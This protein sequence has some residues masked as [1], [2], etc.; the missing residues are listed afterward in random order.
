MGRARPT[1]SRTGCHTTVARQPATQ[2]GPRARSAGT[3]DSFA[4]GTL[5]VASGLPSPDASTI[6]PAAS[7]ARGFLQRDAAC[8]APAVAPQPVAPAEDPRFLRVKGQV[9]QVALKEKS[10]PP[11]KAK[12]AE[13][14]GAAVGP[15]NEVAAQAGAAQVDTMAAA[16]PGTFD[17]AAFIAAVRK[18]IDDAAPKNLDEADNLKNSGKAGLVKDQVAGMVTKGKEDSAKDIKGTTDAPP[19]TSQA[20]PKDVKAMSPESTGSPPPPV[21]GAEAMPAP[22]GPDQTDLGAGPCSIKSKMADAKVTDEQLAK[23]N[24][25]QLNKALDSKQQAEQHAASAPA[26]VKAEEAKQLDAAKSGAGAATTS[27]L[28]SMH[29]ARA[30]VLG[31]VGAG[32]DQ[33]K[34]ADEAKRAEVAKQVEEI[35]NKTKTKVTAILD[36]LDKTVSDAFESGEKA[37]RDAFDASVGR[38]MDAWKDKRYSGISGAAQWLADKFSGPPPEVNEIF[39]RNRAAYVAQMDKVISNVADIVARELGEAKKSIADGRAEVKKFVASQPAAL[40]GVAAE[41]EQKVSEQF[42]S[43]DNDVNSKQDSVVQDLAQKYVAARQSVDDAITKMQEESKGL[44]EEAEEAVEGAVDTIMKMK[45]MLLNVLQRAANA[46][47][48]IIADPIGFLGK[49]VNAVKAGLNQ[50]LSNIVS[51][52]KKGLLGWLFGALAEAGITLPEKFDLKGILNLVLSILG[53]TWANIR[54][55]IVAQIGEPVMAKLEQV[56]EVF[57][58]IVTEGLGGLWKWILQKLGDFKEMVMGQIRS[59]IQ[60][61]VIMAG[62]TWLIGLLNPAAAFIKACKAIYDVVMFFVEK[63]Q[64]IKEFVDSI[65]DSVE[66]ILGGGVGAVANL[67]ENTL[68]KIIPLAISFLASLLGL[69]GIGE[70]IRSI[71]ETIQKPVNKAI[72]TVIGGA[73]KIGK[74]LFGGLIAKGKGLY[75]KGKAYVK[76]KIEAGKAWVKGKVEAGKAWIKGKWEGMRGT[77]TLDGEQHSLKATDEEQPRLLM[78]SADW[79]DAAERMEKEVEVAESS[80]D[81]ARFGRAR[82]LH[83]AVVDLASQF[84]SPSA[85]EPSERARLKMLFS[86]VLNAIANYGREFGRR[87][88]V[89]AGELKEGSIRPYNLQP[90]GGQGEFEH[91]H[92]IPGA[93]FA[94]WLGLNRP[95]SLIKSMYKTMTTLTWKYRAAR[96]KTASDSVKWKQMQNR[97]D[98]WLADPSI[99]RELKR[100]GRVPEGPIADSASLFGP[101]ESL[102]AD[103]VAASIDAASQAGSEVTAQDIEQAASLQLREI[104]VLEK[105]LRRKYQ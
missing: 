61:K 67:I 36:G 72:D 71:I 18:A 66:S 50:F 41:A 60:E 29:G 52:L 81:Q 39:A 6:G 91:E 40:R 58:I 90:K 88:L 49:L 64:Q 83:A 21:P 97:R 105:E 99:A 31:H 80:G 28:G 17:K 89:P 77:F 10:H 76:G 82:A 38:D 94:A 22:R 2:A 59:F 19:D 101:L 7:I 1:V 68:A 54:S 43:L 9:D 78:A 3:T 23:S 47:D 13:A 74:K 48:R 92:I 104:E 37:A 79:T 102:K 75:E 65:L 12:V 51:H 85:K 32:K 14:Q 95:D 56:V 87:G 93:L 46:I 24:E 55:R 63:G 98:D 103:R 70:K 42:D 62:V 11:A 73:L 86:G 53:L 69:G 84:K 25:P 4:G 8:P 26:E 15:P 30:G 100:R 33:A 34:A 45:D 57:K 35:F 96:I 5:P 44:V 16:K 27:G 20:K